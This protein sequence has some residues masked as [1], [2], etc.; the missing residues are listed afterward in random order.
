MVALR[1]ETS[2]VHRS[3]DPVGTKLRR[4]AENQHVWIFSELTM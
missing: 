4:I 1:E 3:G 2:A